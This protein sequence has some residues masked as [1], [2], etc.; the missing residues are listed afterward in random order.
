MRDRISRTRLRIRSILLA[1]IVC[2][3]LGLLPSESRGEND[4]RRKSP[5]IESPGDQ[6]SSGAGGYTGF[7]SANLQQIYVVKKKAAIRT[8]IARGWGKPIVVRLAG[9][10]LLASQYKDLRGGRNPSYP[11]ALEEA[12]LSRSSDE[13]ATWS[14]PRLLGIPG[15][16][17]QFNVLSNQTL[18][19]AIEEPGKIYRSTD[20]G[21]NWTP[22]AIPWAASGELESRRDLILGETSGVVEL[23][24]GKLLS[25]A[26]VSLGPGKSR[27]YVLRSTDNG[28][29]WSDGSFVANASEVSYVVLPGSKL[30]GVARVANNEIGEGDAS[31]AITESDDGGHS[32]TT[33][34][35]VGLGKAQIPGFP[36]Y[37]KDGRLLLIY[38]NRQFPF[39]AQAIASRDEGKTWQ[40]D[41][42]IFLSW[43][44]WDNYCGHPRSFLLPDGSILTAYYTRMFKDNDSP[45]KDIVSQV[46]RWQVPADWP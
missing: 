3:L 46:L 8:Q 41:R 11:N 35:P 33:L 43:F 1:A 40:V 21:A 30:L 37:L 32:W 22:C 16:I 7:N 31:L 27:S 15:R 19:L 14:P 4:S 38:G 9:G 2:G 13:G 5:S 45:N 28:K 18:I 6:R 36:L 25:G 34:R 29:T 42:P 12:A 44:S 26:Y 24:D 17:S 23:P 39:G 10:E 20:R